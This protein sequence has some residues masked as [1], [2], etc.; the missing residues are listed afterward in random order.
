LGKLK[1]RF[2]Q[3]DSTLAEQ[4]EIEELILYPHV[5]KRLQQFGLHYTSGYEP[6]RVPKEQ[7]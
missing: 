1:E 2:R 3:I 6:K 5:A 4:V 7:I